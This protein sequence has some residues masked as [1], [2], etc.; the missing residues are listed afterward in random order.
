MELVRSIDATKLKREKSKEA[1][2]FALEG[3]WKEA[4]LTN[5]DI[6]YY[7]PDDLESLNRLGKSHLELGEYALAKDAFQKVLDRS[8]HNSIAKRNL[9]RLSHLPDARPSS[10]EG[11][12]VAPQLFLEESGK[13][14][15]TDL[16]NLASQDILARVAAGD[17]VTLEPLNNTLVVKTQ[18]G[19]V[20]GLVEPRLGAR[21]A[22]L[23]KQGNQ[24]D[25]AILSAGPAKVSTIIRESFRH[26]S[27]RGVHSFPS[28]GRADRRG[29]VHDAML[30]YDIES[31]PDEELQ[32]DPISM[33]TEDGEEALVPRRAR[34]AAVAP[35]DD[36][37][38]PMADE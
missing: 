32:E 17:S 29:Y 30:S 37:A 20:L 12:K 13:S 26:P 10:S 21:L 36:D 9:S 8:P 28:S 2:Q 18:A 3:R 16:R 27:L 6:L 31:E 23:I 14:G 25:A 22:R 1:I 11:K 38:D 33:W 19:E 7:F 15:V 5:Q 34:P 4:I 24:Y 35:D